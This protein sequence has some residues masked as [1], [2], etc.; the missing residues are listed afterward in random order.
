MNILLIH[1]TEGTVE[2]YLNPESPMVEDTINSF[3]DEYEARGTYISFDI[4]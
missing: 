3:I 2:R 4:V 1:T